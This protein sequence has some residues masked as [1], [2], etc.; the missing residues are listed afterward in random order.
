MLIFSIIP[1]AGFKLRTF[2][3][4]FMIK[5]QNTCHLDHSATTTR[6]QFWLSQTKCFTLL[7]DLIYEVK[8]FNKILLS[9]CE[10]ITTL[11]GLF[12]FIPNQTRTP[13]QR[14]YALLVEH[15]L[16]NPFLILLVKLVGL[17][18]G[19]HVTLKYFSIL[20][21]VSRKHRLFRVKKRKVLLLEVFLLVASYREVWIQ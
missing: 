11:M 4:L 6:S 3:E 8:Y 17:N 16:F 1:Q 12:T 18:K 21:K 14:E 10:K 19:R 5:Q 13:K 15:C 2:Q 7:S 9:L 20:M